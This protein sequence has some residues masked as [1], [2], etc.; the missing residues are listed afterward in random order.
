MDEI[1]N[2]SHNPKSRLMC[3]HKRKM[4][5]STYWPTDSGAKLPSDEVNSHTQ[6]I[7]AIFCDDSVCDIDFQC[8]RFIFG[9]QDRL[10][11]EQRR[12][13]FSYELMKFI[14]F[15]ELDNFR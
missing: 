9:V 11:G 15:Y 13:Y 12:C 5:K 4:A 3:Y 14:Y 1:Y 6:I 2:R 7:W 10:F 8:V